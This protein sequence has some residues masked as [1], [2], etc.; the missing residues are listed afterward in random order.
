MKGGSALDFAKEIV[1]RSERQASEMDIQDD[2]AEV[3][4]KVQSGPGL[5]VTNI[6]QCFWSYNAGRPVTIW[7]SGV[8]PRQ[9]V[10]HELANRPHW[11][12]E[13]VKPIRAMRPSRSNDGEVVIKTPA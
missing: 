2:L 6:G 11:T 10:L 9:P 12:A 13:K 8:L 4:N 1:N 7:S 5:I 3:K